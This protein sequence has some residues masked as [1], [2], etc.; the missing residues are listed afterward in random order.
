M[1]NGKTDRDTV[2]EEVI[3]TWRESLINLTGRNRLLNFTVTKTSTV[4]V[5]VP[6]PAM[7]LQRLKGQ[8]PL[9]FAAL[10]PPPTVTDPD[11]VAALAADADQQGPT[12]WTDP[13]S[14]VES[15][16]TLLGANMDPAALRGALRTLMSRSNQTFMDTGLRTLYIALGTL[17]WVDPEDTKSRFRSPLILIPVDLQSTGPRSAPLLNQEEQEDVVVNPALVLKMQTLGFQIPDVDLEE[18]NA[19][20]AYLQALEHEIAQKEGW[21]VGRDAHLSYFTFYKEAMYRDLQDNID[22]ILASEQVRALAGSGLANQSEDLLFDPVPDSRVDE[23]DPPE[24][25]MQVLDADASQ[26]AAI[27]AAAEGRSFVIDGPPGTGK[28]Q[29]I[30]NII[31]TL[32]PQGRSVLFVS[33]KAAALEVVKNR[34]EEVGLGSYVL[35]LHS[36][37][38]TRKEVAEELANAVTSRPKGPTSLSSTALQRLKKAR[39]EL[40]HYAAEMNLP[41]DPLGMAPHDAMGLVSRYEDLPA[42][43]LCTGTLTALGPGD[44][45]DIQDAADRLG[46]AWRPALQGENF[47]WREAAQR[48]PLTYQLNQARDALEQLRQVVAGNEPLMNALGWDRPSD[49]DHLQALLTLWGTRP[50]DAPTA[51]LQAENVAEI[52]QAV[53]AFR[54]ALTQLQEAQATALAVG[55]PYW[56]RLQDDQAPL[57]FTSGRS[58]LSAL[59]PVGPEIGGMTAEQIGQAQS[60]LQALEDALGRISDRATN[61]APRLGLLPPRTLDDAASIVEVEH[62][63]RSAHRPE[64]KWLRAE[65]DADVEVGLAALQQA[66]GDCATGRTAAGEYFTGRV[67]ELDPEALQARFENVHTGLHKLGSAY[68]ADVRSLGQASVPGIKGKSNIVNLPAA[69]RWQQALKHREEVEGRYATLIGPRYR[70]EETD[71]HALEDA[72]NTARA[73]ARAA[74]NSVIEQL[75]NAVGNGS[76]LDPQNVEL[77]ANV[78]ADL[79]LIRAWV[80]AHGTVITTTVTSEP[81]SNQIEWSG[82]V[83]SALVDCERHLR[84]VE[85]LLQPASA[86]T[87]DAASDA[88]TWAAAARDLQHHCDEADPNWS[89]LLDRA[90]RGP[91]TDL[92]HLGDCLA[93]ATQVRDLLAVHSRWGTTTTGALSTDQVKALESN[94]PSPALRPAIADHRAAIDAVVDAFS[95]DRAGELRVQLDSWAE[96]S[97][98]LTGLLDDSVGQDEWFSYREAYEQLEPWGL[99]GTINSAAMIRLPGH[100]V[101]HVILRETLRRWIDEV[102]E[103]R[104]ALQTARHS[105]RD[106]VVEEF[107]QLDRQLVQSTVGNVIERANSF[108]PTSTLGQAGVILNEG[109]K[110][111]RHMPIR[112]LIGRTKDVALVVKPIFMMSPLSVSQYIPPDLKFDVVIFD[113][114]SQVMPEDAVNCI[115]RGRSL[116]IAGDEKQLPPTNFFALGSTD[117]EENW[118]EDQSSAKDFESVLSIAKGCGAFTSLTLTWH[119][120]SRHEDLIAFSNNRFYNGELVTFPSAQ[121]EGPDVGVEFFLVPDGAYDRAGS[122]RNLKEARFVAQRIAHHYDTRPGMSLGVVAFSQPQADAIQLALDEMLAN[123]PDLEGKSHG[124]RLDALFIKN[125]ETVQG[126]ERDVMIFSVGYGPD[127]VG[128]LTMNFGPINRDGGWR[129]LNVA[130]T[131]ARYRNE[132][133]ASFQSAQMTL[134][135]SRSLNEFRRYLDYAANGA[136]ALALD[137]RA[138]QGDVESPF[139]ESVVDWL[140]SQGYLVSTQVGTSG[141]RIDMAVRHPEHAS[142]FVL[143]IECDGA[144]YHSSQTARDRDR[145]REQV[146]VGLGW[147]L[148][149]IW[150]TAWYR[151]RTDEQQR[152]RNAIEDAIAAPPRGL[153]PRMTGNRPTSTVEIGF[154]EVALEAIA[155][156]AVPY[157]RAQP[158]RPPHYILP[159]EPESIPWH[160]KIINVV[161]AAEGPVH[162]ELVDQR[163]REAWGIGRI[164]GII[165]SRIEAGIMHA[166]VRRDGSFLLRQDMGGT[167]P[168]RIHD[169]ETKRDIAHV[170]PAEI[171][172]TAHRVTRD[173]GAIDFDALVV[174]TARHLGF[175][176]VGDDVRAAVTTAIRSL[177]TVGWI[178][179]EDGRI[180]ILALPGE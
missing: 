119:Y 148:H 129:R 178:S 118:E 83:R 166:G 75:A 155:E 29:T 58:Q 47:L 78:S 165:R 107:R 23:L 134:S 97:D 65:V 162:L 90:Y 136:S 147:N 89:R 17:T 169:A 31:A 40:S 137:D 12:Q 59:T 18:T 45:A 175:A 48:S 179:N 103:A 180:R 144:R 152:L 43:R 111:K 64:G 143:G 57:A 16:P 26:R 70:R 38:A 133:I 112:D 20:P 106:S 1:G 132:V 149:R 115:Y 153:L 177:Q 49:A 121:D 84:E 98:L 67:L 30:T 167:F 21:A 25:A 22:Q 150:G 51:W 24:L 142:R 99:A 110:K 157:Q 41:Q 86:L 54:V 9:S 62:L 130:I 174:S 128:K 171:K 145:L 56:T 125:L 91:A 10:R 135:A 34:L 140:R 126:D 14:Q 127:A 138:S 52:R 146:L 27:V 120:R 76:Q 141:Y 77:A 87:F 46:R 11:E 69:A 108:R 13:R 74:K 158:P 173:A 164:G 117:E 101:P 4:P 82:A 66:N 39:L 168:T 55:G 37:K 80:D 161:V 104:P 114:A 95:P 88:A 123:R 36:H 172:V 63:S 60:Q 170:H 96:G 72:L 122:R 28:S 19:L 105:E 68:R 163:L 116:I 73:I 44:L 3:R 151:H 7:V 139:E 33:E 85:I 159:S 93:W 154:E 109:R 156:W 5:T 15:S 53:E 61:L 102:L 79:E 35:E 124:S 160:A 94:L 50:E 81:I 42:V 176:R 2:I 100:D 32:I 113:E 131:R 92:N 6:D 8:R 71:W